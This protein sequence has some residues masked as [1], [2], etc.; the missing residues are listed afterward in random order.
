MLVVAW[1]INFA[2]ISL[3]QLGARGELD[4]GMLNLLVPL[5][6]L[7]LV[8]H[9]GLRLVARDADPL[10]VPIASVL[11]GLGIAMI[12]RLDLAEGYSGWE[13]ASVRQIVWTA[14]AIAIAIGVVLVIRNHRVLQRYS[15]IAMFSGI[16]LLLLPM[17]PVIGATKNGARLWIEVGPFSFQPG[18]LGKIAL[19]IFFAGYLVTARDSLSM[20]G[21]RSLASPCRERA[22]SARF[23]SS[24]PPR[25]LCSSSSATSVRRCCTS[26]CFS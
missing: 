11:N 24:S 18:E 14:L 8:L 10:I 21:R 7:V 1:G 13:S 20:V 26:D 4:I 17:L 12:Y 23:L 6:V 5:A 22:T 25:W 15:Y 9:L 2:A 16:V 3:V 19:A